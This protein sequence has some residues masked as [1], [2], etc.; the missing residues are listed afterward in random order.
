MF[1][2]PLLVP[3][4]ERLVRVTTKFLDLLTKKVTVDPVIVRCLCNHSVLPENYPD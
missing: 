2:A 1:D 3:V 4:D